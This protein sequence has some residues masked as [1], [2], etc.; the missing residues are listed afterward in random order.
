[1]SVPPLPSLR[2]LTR[3]LRFIHERLA[4][5]GVAEQIVIL[6]QQGVPAWRWV[7]VVGNAQGPGVYARE[8][9]PGSVERECEC[10]ALLRKINARQDQIDAWPCT[11]CHGTGRVHVPSPFDATAAARRLLAAARDATLSTPTP[12]TDKE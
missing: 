1:V 12:P 4:E 2:A 8:T 9:I 7:V 10:R 11:T 3:E 6:V 5:I